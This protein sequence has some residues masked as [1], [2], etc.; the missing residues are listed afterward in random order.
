MNIKKHELEACSLVLLYEIRYIKNPSKL[1]MCQMGHIR[2]TYIT[3]EGVV[4][5]KTFQGDPL[6]GLVNESRSNVYNDS[7]G[8][9]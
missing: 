6:K 5:L 8:L 2:I 1:R 9:E 3:K 4:K 7:K